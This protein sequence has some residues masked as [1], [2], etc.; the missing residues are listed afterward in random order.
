M[1]LKHIFG[2]SL[3]KVIFKSGGKIKIS[4]YRPILVF[5]CFSKILERLMH[6]RLYEYLLCNTVIPRFSAP[7]RLLI[8][9]VLEEALI[10]GGRLFEGGAYTRGALI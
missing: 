4:N 8:Q 1:P 5:S 9:T 6:N 10:R 7:G 2:L 3:I